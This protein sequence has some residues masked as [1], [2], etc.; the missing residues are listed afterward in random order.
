MKMNGIQRAARSLAIGFFASTAAFSW[1]TPPHTTGL[2]VNL[3]ADNATR[4]SLGGANND[5]VAVWLDLA[6]DGI[7]EGTF[8]NFGNPAELNQPNYISNFVMPNGLP[9]G[10]VDFD[11]GPVPDSPSS[12]RPQNSHAES[13]WLV[14][15]MGGA[16]GPFVGGGDPAY[17]I[18]DT[19]AVPDGLSFFVVWK[20]DIVTNRVPDSDSSSND[21]R[22]ARQTILA[23]VDANPLLSPQY[24]REIGEDTLTTVNVGSNTVPNHYSHIRNQLHPTDG[25]GFGSLNPPLVDVTPNWYISAVSANN[26]LG[27]ATLFRTLQSDGTDTGTTS[28]GSSDFSTLGE[29]AVHAMTLIGQAVNNATATSSRA[30]DGQLAEI[31]IYNT[32]LTEMEFGDIFSY[33]NDKYFANV[34][35]YNGDGKVNAADYVVWRQNPGSFPANAYDTWRANFGVGEVAGSSLGNGAV[36]EPGAVVL[37]W[38]VLATMGLCRMHR[39]SARSRG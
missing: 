27:G 24:G 2:F 18:G 38:A 34:A 5:K 12:A 33:L 32:A 35:D 10:V 29:G 15:Q 1:A 6:T 11:R 28:L 7:T 9:M 25:G 30:F 17:E 36:P 37:A 14:S 19:P 26:E 31:L 16:S 3:N 21:A 20:T 13:D 39:D 23:S 22:K 4:F 8:Q